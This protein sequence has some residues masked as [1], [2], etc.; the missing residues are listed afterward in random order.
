MLDVSC[1]NTMTFEKL[2]YEFI[3]EQKYLFGMYVVILL[4][5]PIRD[6][7]MPHYIGKLYDSIKKGKDSILYI[8]IIIGIVIMVQVIYIFSDYIDIKMHP[9]LYKFIREKMMS[10]VF[11]T[12]ENNYSDVDVG[13][14]I[15]KIIKLPSI[16]HH[17]IELIRWEF[18]PDII[19]ILATIAYVTYIDWTL[20]LPLLLVGAIFC[21]TLAYSFTTCSPDALK[22]DEQFTL[23]MSSI[24]DIMKNMLTVLNFDKVGAEFERMDELNKEYAVYTEKTLSCSLVNKYIIIA[25]M[26]AYISFACYYSFKQVKKGAMTGGTAVTLLILLFVVMNK[27]FSIMGIWQD[28]IMRSGIIENAIQTFE[29]CKTERTPYSEPAR[30][31]GLAFQDVDFSYVSTDMQ[32]PVFTKFNL[33]IKMNQTTLIVGEIGSGKSTLISLLMKFQTPQK[34]EI[35][36]KGVPFSTMDTKELRRRISFIPQ[37]PIL[38]NRTVYENIV[39]GLDHKTKEDVLALMR[40]M[41]LDGF[42]TG[43]PKGLDTSVGIHGSKLSGGQRQIIWVLKTLLSNPEI[44]IMDEPTAAIDDTTKSIVQN[45]LSQTMKGKTVIMITHDPYLLKYANRVIT[46]ENGTVIKDTSRG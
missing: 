26:L 38:L 27:I 33:D 28:V 7:A 30:T 2:L 21:G 37:S 42:L 13:E 6:V 24:N 8:G 22:R 35:F 11:Q 23:I 25:C 15:T 32:R 3:G 18:I 1:S 9:A 5:F 14:I 43:L 19:T 16:M 46:M 39:Y 31:N 41:K 20:G 34:G 45:L 40:T 44:I 10:H 36:L 17:H 4:F 29:E 12:K